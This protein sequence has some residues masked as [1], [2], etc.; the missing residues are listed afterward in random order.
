VIEFSP[1]KILENIVETYQVLGNAYLSGKEA[2]V[3][4]EA[5]SL[6]KEWVE[7][8]YDALRFKVTFC[9]D[10]LPSDF[11][12][13]RQ[14]I[15]AGEL[16]VYDGGSGS[17]WCDHET[18][19][20]FRAVHDYH[21]ALASVDFT[22]KGEYDAYHFGSNRLHQWASD[23][24]LPEEWEREA[25]RVLFSEIVLQAAAFFILGDFPETQKVVYL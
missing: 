14:Q 13:I 24:C 21:H 23:E 7:Y 16:R 25:D 8:E 18:N 6:L 4:V 11:N 19:L 2:T 15:E 9:S 20:K 10:G 3:S 5:K 17:V 22:F 12:E 1:Y